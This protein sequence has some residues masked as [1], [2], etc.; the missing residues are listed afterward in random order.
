MPR[1]NLAV[2]MGQTR[3]LPRKLQRWR[4]SRKIFR[5]SCQSEQAHGFPAHQ[6]LTHACAQKHTA[7]CVLEICKGLKAQPVGFI[8]DKTGKWQGLRSPI[9]QLWC[10][11]I[12]RWQ[13][14]RRGHRRYFSLVHFIAHSFTVTLG[15]PLALSRP[16]FLLERRLATSVAV[17]MCHSPAGSIKGRETEQLTLPHMQTIPVLPSL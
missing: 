14:I 3:F 5:T 7:R 9:V 10:W 6:T 1:L 16:H 12:W 11:I 17:V 13:R 4:V 2:T 8:S 15:L